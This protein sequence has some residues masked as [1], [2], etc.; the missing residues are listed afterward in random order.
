MNLGRADPARVSVLALSAAAFLLAFTI[1]FLCSLHSR[2]RSAHLQVGTTVAAV[3]DRRADVAPSF[4]TAQTAGLKPAATAATPRLVENYGRFPLS[5]E[6]NNGQ[7]DSQVRF[8]S[9]GRGYTMF[10]TQ[11]EAVLSLKKPSAFSTQLSALRKGMTSAMPLSGPVSPLALAPEGL[12]TR[13]DESNG[14][15]SIDNRQFPNPESQTP[16]VLRLKL[17]GANPAAKVNGLQELPGRSNYFL[18]NDPKKW[19]TNV[20]NYRKVK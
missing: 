8:L 18:G 12:L 7:T 14:Q 4:R 6:A 13:P 19:R 17:V 15:S 2:D 16:A 1:P 20:S 5:F 3:S 9:R 11:N 10:L